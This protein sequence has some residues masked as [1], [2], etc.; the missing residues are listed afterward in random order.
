MADDEQVP[1]APDARTPNMARMYDYA[2]GGK[3]NYA[4]DRAAIEKL[5]QMSPENR[6][7]PKANRR[8]LDR[9]V[10]FVAGQ[11]IR[12]FLDLGARLSQSGQCA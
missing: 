8:F 9:A 11:G 10:R 2:L 12:Q 3:D 6:Y 4:V 1:T 7:V 5:F